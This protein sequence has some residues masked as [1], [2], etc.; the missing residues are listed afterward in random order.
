MVVSILGTITLFVGTMQALKQ[1]QSKR[2]LAFGGTGQIGYMLF[3][4][5]TCMALLA[6]KTPAT[7]ALATIALMG[8]LFHVL[9]HGIFKGLLFLNAGSMFYATGTQDLNQMG[10]LMKFMPLTAITALIASFSI[11]G[12]P[13]LNGCSSVSGRFGWRRSRGAVSPIT[14]LS[15]Q[16][17]Q[18]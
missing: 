7:A 18:S 16:S 6:V 10:G 9:N 14:L 17:S 5:G 12:V 15:A 2:L 1:E 8:A 4:I 13:L 11:S 3:G